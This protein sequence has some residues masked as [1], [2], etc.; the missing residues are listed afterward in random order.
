VLGPVGRG[1]QVT[2]RGSSDQVLLFVYPCSLHCGGDGIGIDGVAG[3]IF[4]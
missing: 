2:S 1:R 3:G 4:G